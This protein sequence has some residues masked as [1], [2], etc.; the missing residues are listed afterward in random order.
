[1]L[2]LRLY[3]LTCRLIY[4]LTY[5]LLLFDDFFRRER[6]RSP[7]SSPSYRHHE[8]DHRYRDDRS[9][10]YDDRSRDY[11]DRSRDYDERSRDSRYQSSYHRDYWEKDKDR[12]R[13]DYHNAVDSKW[14]RDAY[15]HDAKNWDK[16]R[17]HGDN[18]NSS[19]S[20]DFQGSKYSK[21][22]SFHRGFNEK[23]GSPKKKEHF[24][25]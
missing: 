10:D 8:K 15:R 25:D 1:M 12:Y 14:G 11:D 5:K 6:S 18:S 17:D 23:R 9:R 22:D 2:L 4:L 3:L 24:Q 21:K 20:H 19:H 13:G 7:V 16:D